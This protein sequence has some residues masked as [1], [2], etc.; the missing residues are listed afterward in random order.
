M[1]KKTYQVWV[2]AEARY[3]LADEL[4]PDAPRSLTVVDA[5]G[6]T[7]LCLGLGASAPEVMRRLDAAAAG[8]P[9][10][11]YDLRACGHTG[12]GEDVCHLCVIGHVGRLQAA[13]E[14]GMSST[15][16]ARRRWRDGPMRDAVAA[17]LREAPLAE[18]LGPEWYRVH[19]EH[20]GHWPMWWRDT[21]E[22]R[23]YKPPLPSARCIGASMYARPYEIEIHEVL[24]QAPRVEHR[25]ELLPPGL[26]HPA[27]AAEMIVAFGLP[28]GWLDDIQLLRDDPGP[29]GAMLVRPPLYLGP[30]RGFRYGPDE[31]V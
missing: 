30:G 31:E 8:L 22:Y 15:L 23:L 13:L 17:W 26:L 21:G 3:A 7:W 5:E 14:R 1:P 16:D 12:E 27:Q 2:R 18:Q 10:G 4:P 6:R 25:G 28:L 24:L 20:P 29:G 11:R 19:R 9:P